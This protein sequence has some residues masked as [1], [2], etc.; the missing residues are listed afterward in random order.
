VPLGD[1]RYWLGWLLGLAFAA[2]LVYLAWWGLFGDRE[3]G[4]RRCPRCWFDLTGTPREPPEL[5]CGECG[6]SP[7]RES[8][9]HRVRRRWPSA[10]L[11]FIALSLGIA[12][13][14]QRAGDHG[15]ASLL[16]TRGLIA[17]MP[18]TAPSGS[19]FGEL[20]LRLRRNELSTG[21]LTMLVDRCVAGDWGARPP[22][23]PWG[24]KYGELLRFWSPML[25]GVEGLDERLLAIPPRVDMVVRDPWPAG[26]PVPVMVRAHDWWP[27]EMELRLQM[28]PRMAGG[29][30]VTIVRSGDRSSGAVFAL[31]LP[32]QE[33]GLLAGTV[34]VELGRRLPGTQ[35]WAALAPQ[36]VEVRARIEEVR[37]GEMG[38]EPVDS[39]E[40][41]EAVMRV[42]AP[43]A[44]RWRRGPSP[45]RF[46]LDAE[47][48]FWP[49]FDDVAIG[50]R[51][52]LV[53]EEEVARR[54]AVWWRAGPRVP[55]HERSMG[56]EVQH[57]DETLLPLVAADG[58]WWWRVTGDPALAL[59]AGGGTKY[60]AG[61]V[62]VPL[63][64]DQEPGLAPPRHWQVEE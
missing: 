40:L 26:V 15:W 57:E 44:V 37:G 39:P 29:A 35:E 59:R 53:R 50:V 3:K 28:T 42:V 18:F 58:T 41:D 16:P 52:E 21:E 17:L 22:S 63:A 51:I 62:M 27:Q 20:S 5:T 30:P 46:R 33:P 45:V 49:V 2:G 54:L 13:V 31:E 10:V 64:L 34:E 56:W 36:A 7:A 8:E 60:W 38:L 14:L 24:G 12:F 61:Q 4:R 6:Y 32:G 43:G 23:V 55:R 9:L 19:I 11:A 1:L 47:R 25:Q 48:T